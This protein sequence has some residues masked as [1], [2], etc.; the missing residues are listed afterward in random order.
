M[1]VVVD[2]D[3]AWPHLFEFLRAT[4]R[5][6]LSGVPV[7]A[8]EHI[9]STSVPGLSAK[10]VIDVDIVV[11]DGHVDQA[12]AAM[13]SLGFRSLGERGIESRWALEAPARLPA[14]NTYVVVE[15]SLAYRNHVGVR[16]T[17][18]GDPELRDEYAALKAS[19][20]ARVE[21]IDSYVEAKSEFLA[22]VLQRAGLTS[23]ELQLIR[24]SNRAR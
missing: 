15:H 11:S 18:R 5:S 8:I 20:A 17:L 9:G 21:D 24:Q 3:P 2:S 4:Y 19:I 14:T 1:I 23:D 7:R 12:I 22:G 10:P 6:A 16:D 13:T